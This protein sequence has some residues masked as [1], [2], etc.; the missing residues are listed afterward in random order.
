MTIMPWTGPGQNP[1]QPWGQGL[2][3]PRRRRGLFGASA[4]VPDQ[5][6]MTAVEQPL[7][8]KPKFFGDG[9]V[10]RAI[11][12]NIGDFLLQY[13]GMQPT[14]API[15]QQRQAAQQAERQ[16]QNSLADWVWKQ[17]YE[18]AH[19]PRTPTNYEQILD[20]A[21]IQGDERIALLRRKA[22]NDAAG[23]PVGIDVQ[24]PDGSVTRQYVRPGT[25]GGGQ[26]GPAVGAIE[27]GY[28]FKGGNP[29]DK[30]SWEPVNGGP[31]PT[32]SGG[33]PDPLKAPGQLTS[34][35]RTVEGNRLVGG[36]PNSHHLTGDGVDYTGTTVAALRA[37]FGPNARILDEGDHKHVTLPG[38]GKVPYFGKRGT[39][40]LKR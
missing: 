28:R 1:E 7:A 2:M 26:S 3:G 16:R 5:P 19:K 18:A 6:A 34:G 37:Y 14:Y 13:S 4:Q 11:A 39:T 33:F 38:Y 22:E 21:G 27:D 35:R 32:A 40:G 31:T 15:M 23:V 10:G 30:N 36:V 8:P 12:G 24:N 9:G 29:A 20:A 25:F 17:D